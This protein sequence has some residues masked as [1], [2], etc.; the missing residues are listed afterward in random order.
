ME[1]MENMPP[2]PV[3]ALFV[4]PLVAVMGLLG[5]SRRSSLSLA[6]TSGEPGASPYR[7]SRGEDAAAFTLSDQRTEDWVKFV[8]VLVTV[9]GGLFVVWIYPPTGLADEFVDALEGLMGGNTEATMMLILVI[10]GIA[11][12]GLAGL[13]PKGEAIIGERAYR[14]LFGLVSLPLAILALV[15]FI[16]H[17]YDGTLLWDIKGVPGVHSAVWILTFISFIFL[18]PSTFNLLE[19][20][21]VEKPKLHMWE[22]GIMR[23]TRHPQFVGQGLWCI[24][25]TAWIGSSFA[26]VT[27][28]GLMAHH[29]F[30]VWHGDRRLFAKY[31]EAFEEVK[32][33]TSIWPFAAI[34]D[35]RQQLPKDYWLEFARGPYLAI[36]V[37]TV[38][39]YF[40]HPLMQLGSYSL[41]W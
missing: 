35:G 13:R 1:T 25:H 16:N 3:W 5:V 12:S 37:G 14:V 11:H 41:H 7:T 18:Y 21:A 24:A 23:I 27:S 20:A 36:V 34:L 10:F 31:G 17:R 8:A 40:A 26:V 39:A 4:A 30:G 33:R 2:S 32:A 22:T 9:L 6:S 19:I 38:G 29:T 28:I 15:Y